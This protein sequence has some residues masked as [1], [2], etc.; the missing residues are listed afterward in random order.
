MI[1]SE[2][3]ITK[4]LISLRGWA[5]WSAPVLVANPEDRFYRVDAHMVCAYRGMC[6][7]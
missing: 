4:A 7:N 1:L 6:A 3:Q 5:G 2:T